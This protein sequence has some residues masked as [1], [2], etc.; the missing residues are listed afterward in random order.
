MKLKILFYLSMVSCML[1]SCASNYCLRALDLGPKTIEYY[2]GEMYQ[3][4]KGNNSI[5]AIT[6]KKQ[7]NKHM[8]F[9]I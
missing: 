9:L 5:V 4:S 3:V 8:E 1:I 7:D 6:L 2:N